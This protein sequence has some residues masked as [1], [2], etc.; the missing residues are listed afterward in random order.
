MKVNISYRVVGDTS[1]RA[2]VMNSS[3]LELADSP[4]RLADP[5]PT[6]VPHITIAM[7]QVKN[8]HE[9]QTIVNIVE[10]IARELC[11]AV[12]GFGHPYREGATGRYIF[13]DAH[14]PRELEEARSAIWLRLGDVFVEE[15]R[16]SNEAHLT[17]GH[18]EACLEQVDQFL[19]LQS[20]P[21][22]APS[23]SSI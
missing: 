5:N 16:R 6:S 11:P 13:A 14:L 9:I 23:N 12:V 20:A 18:V 1:E 2:K 21:R 7:G 22:T 4:I 19:A 8:A 15:A 10:P 17:L 3:L